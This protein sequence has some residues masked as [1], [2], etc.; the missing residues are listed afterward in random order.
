MNKIKEKYIY[1]KLKNWEKDKNLLTKAQEMKEEKNTLLKK[2]EKRKLTTT[3]RLTF[4]LFINCTLIQ[5]FTLYVLLKQLNMGM[6]VDLTPLQMLI[7]TIVGEVIVFAIYSIKSLKENTKGGIIYQTTL[8]EQ[9]S[10]LNYNNDQ[11]A[12]G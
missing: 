9:N 5:I 2:E 8:N 4:F 7:T 1:K 3:K 11:E 12:M 10:L 6:D